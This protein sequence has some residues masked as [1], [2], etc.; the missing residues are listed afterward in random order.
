MIVLP[1]ELDVETGE[2]IV[3]SRMRFVET[4]EGSTCRTYST[5]ARSKHLRALTE[6]FPAPRSIPVLE[7]KLLVQEQEWPLLWARWES[8]RTYW[9]RE[10]V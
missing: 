6:P 1:D 4:F 3:T 8:L 2:P 5:A 7:P 10:T 9:E